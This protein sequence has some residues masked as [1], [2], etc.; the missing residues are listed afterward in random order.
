MS[1]TGENEQGLRKI[2]D[3]TRFSCIFILLL[4]FYY[5]CYAAFKQW[6]IK[7]TFINRLLKNIMHTG[8]FTSQ[9]ISKFLTFGLLIISLL[10]AQGK[11]D[12]KNHSTT[13]LHRHAAWINGLRRLFSQKSANL[14]NRFGRGHTGKRHYSHQCC[15]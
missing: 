9:Y 1:G 12:E 3:L 8:L 6:E 13:S 11:K 10:G 5:Y 7:S 15:R 14:N 4:H 2:V